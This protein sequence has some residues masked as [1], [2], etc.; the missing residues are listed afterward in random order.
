MAMHCQRQVHLALD[1][2]LEFIAD[3]V[4]SGG[5]AMPV[6][7]LDTKYKIDMEPN[8]A[9][10]GQVVAYAQHLGCTEAVLVYPTRDHH[11]I[12]IAVGDIHVRSL[13]YPLDGDLD[14]GGQALIDQLQLV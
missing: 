11:P 8:P 12:D 9:D 10:I 14:L 2:H 1:Q 13:A 3:L 7:V 6:A 5:D 4:I